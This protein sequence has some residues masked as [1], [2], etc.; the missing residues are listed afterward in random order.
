MV[1]ESSPRSSTQDSPLTEVSGTTSIQEALFPSP[2]MVL[3]PILEQEGSELMNESEPSSEGPESPPT[4]LTNTSS[5]PVV[6]ETTSNPPPALQ[7][8]IWGNILNNVFLLD[9][10]PSPRLYSS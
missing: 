2:P 8:S 3:D 1:S 4:P 7:V 10:R 6:L 5:V 9:K